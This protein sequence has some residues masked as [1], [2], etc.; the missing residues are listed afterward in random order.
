MSSVQL[1]FVTA[2]ILSYGVYC[3]GRITCLDNHEKPV[4]WLVDMIVSMLFVLQAHHFSVASRT[5]SRQGII[6]GG[7]LWHGSRR[8]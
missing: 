4:D 7:G 5:G 2:S 6:S 8:I 1:L 3:H